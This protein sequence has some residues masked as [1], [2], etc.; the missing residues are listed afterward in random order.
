MAKWQTS[1]YLSYLQ[2][3]IL[4]H[5]FVTLSTLSLFKISR[6][7]LTVSYFFRETL[8]LLLLICLFID[9]YKVSSKYQ[10]LKTSYPQCIKKVKFELFAR[11]HSCIVCLPLG[12]F[13][14]LAYTRT[15]AMRTY[16]H[17]KFGCKITKNILY[18]QIFPQ[19]KKK[20]LLFS[21]KKETFTRKS[22]LSCQLSAIS[23]QI[24][25]C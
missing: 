22:L 9:I 25:E 8:R 17:N 5:N 20:N 21:Q 24:S 18:I 23:C 4:C 2:P 12:S 10:S 13:V 11:N 16:A 1:T 19:K 7:G 14:S 6:D 3:F 15:Q